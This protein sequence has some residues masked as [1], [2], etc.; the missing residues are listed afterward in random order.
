MSNRIKE[1][2]VN[3]GGNMEELISVI[4]DG[5]AFIEVLHEISRGEAEKEFGAQFEEDIN[6]L[7]RKAEADHD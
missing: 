2:N 6:Q 3:Q 5:S 7:N 1:G 4:D